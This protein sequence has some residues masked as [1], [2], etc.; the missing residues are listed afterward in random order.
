MK[1]WTFDWWC[2][3]PDITFVIWGLFPVLFSCYIGIA[4]FLWKM[5]GKD[6]KLVLWVQKLSVIFLGIFPPALHQG[7]V[8]ASAS[9][10]ILCNLR[11]FKFVDILIIVIFYTRMTLVAYVRARTLCTWKSSTAWNFSHNTSKAFLKRKS[12]WFLTYF[13]LNKEAF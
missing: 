3:Q 10:W 7:W 2:L 5:M 13:K 1:T 11:M 8:S 6:C 9:S 4:L 12:L